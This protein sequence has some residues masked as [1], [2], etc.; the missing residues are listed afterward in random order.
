MLDCVKAYGLLHKLLNRIFGLCKIYAEIQLWASSNP[1]AIP[2][3]G[4]N[5]FLFL[6]ISAISFQLEDN[7]ANLLLR[8]LNLFKD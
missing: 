7:T 8:P 1:K 6:V 3:C 5:T 4:I 2:P